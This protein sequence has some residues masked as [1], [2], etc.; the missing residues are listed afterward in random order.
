MSLQFAGAPRCGIRTFRHACA[1]DERVL[2][3]KPHTAEPPVPCLMS[4]STVQA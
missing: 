2:R 3:M 1:T 4:R